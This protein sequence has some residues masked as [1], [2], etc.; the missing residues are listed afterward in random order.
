MFP[1]FSLIIVELYSVRFHKYLAYAY[2]TEKGEEKN[3]TNK[4]KRRKPGQGRIT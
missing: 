4:K 2:S 1:V 3:Q